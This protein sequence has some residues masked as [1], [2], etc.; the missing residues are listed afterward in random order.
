MK[1]SYAALFVLLIQASSSHAQVGGAILQGLGESLQ[2]WAVLEQQRLQAEELMQRQ[3]ELDM[4]RIEREHELRLDQARMDNLRREADER[5]R[6]WQ[7]K[8]ER[9]HE[10]AKMNAAHPGWVQTVR[11]DSFRQWKN[12][13][14]ASVQALGASDRADDAILMLDLYKR[15]SSRQP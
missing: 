3:H 12:Q 13:Q 6:I 14:P 5:A 7:E 10:L 15:D 11:S 1:T 8:K 4:R 9:E 2:R